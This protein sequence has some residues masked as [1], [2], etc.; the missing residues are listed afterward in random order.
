MFHFHKYED[1]VYVEPYMFEGVV[2]KRER[3]SGYKICAKCDKGVKIEWCSGGS[4]DIVLSSDEVQV[5]KEK[6][7]EGKFRL[8]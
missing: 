8:K 5:L 7:N 6:I 4:Y 3:Y 2:L 1:L